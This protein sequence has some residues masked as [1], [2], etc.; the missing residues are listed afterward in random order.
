[1]NRCSTPLIAFILIAIQ[2]FLTL[3]TATFSLHSQAQMQRIFPPGIQRAEIAF[4]NAPPLVQLNGKTERLAPGVRVRDQHNM[5]ALTGTLR[6]KSFVANY[7]RDPAGAIR[8]VW[9]LTEREAAQPLKPP[10]STFVVPP[11]PLLPAS[12]AVNT[13]PSVYSN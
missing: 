13:G 7:L 10:V 8:E 1:M 6:G 11:N 3:A 12:A 5:I 9:L 2:A 4:G